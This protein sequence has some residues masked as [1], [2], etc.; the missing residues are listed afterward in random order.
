MRRRELV[1]AVALQAQEMLPVRLAD[2]LHDWDVLPARATRRDGPR[3]LT[4]VVAAAERQPI[5][6]A[7]T[8]AADA[9][10]VVDSVSLAPLALRAA[11]SVAS[12]FDD[13]RRA[14]A[15]R[16][17]V[18]VD[19]ETSTIVT[20]RGGIPEL[21]TA[22]DVGCG[23][24]LAE[25]IAVM[26]SRISASGATTGGEAMDD[27]ASISSAAP[28]PGA[29]TW[30]R[31][32]PAADTASGALAEGLAAALVDC[33]EAMGSRL[34]DVTL[35][36]RGALAPGLAASLA[37]LLDVPASLYSA[38]PALPGGAVGLTDADLQRLSPRLAVALGLALDTERSADSR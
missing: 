16:A 34:A 14:T 38:A 13:Q 23:R 24:V 1:R 28:F 2:L 4:V 31:S 33:E 15:T 5:E 29:L 18:D 21:T 17:I 11:L 10:L 20:L 9:G 12:V 37:R 3:H 32:E 27:E 6:L 26:P 7:L 8:A 19:R 36:G 35:C 22:T 25:T 30:T